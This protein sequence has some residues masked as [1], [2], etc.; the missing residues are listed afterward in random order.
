MSYVF[1][2]DSLIEAHYR[3]PISMFPTTLWSAYR[4]GIHKQEIIIIK[5]VYDE[6][7]RSSDNLSKWLKSN[8]SYTVDQLDDFEVVEKA[9]EI[10]N[11]F[12]LL[13][14]PKKPLDQADPYTIAF[15]TVHNHVVVTQE[16]LKPGKVNVPHICN[17]LNVR[18]IGLH[19]FYKEICW[20]F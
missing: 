10:I 14:N 20:C 16:K 2:T 9:K 15:A 3:T 4:E 12:P 11:T 18:C 7:T 8:N 6:V 13:I 1:D 19:E 5:A 17:T